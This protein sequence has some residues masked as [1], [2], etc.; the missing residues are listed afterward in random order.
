[1][2]QILFPFFLILPGPWRADSI[3][4]WTCYDLDAGRQEFTVGANSG[5][6][7]Y[8]DADMYFSGDRVWVYTYQPRTIAWVQKPF[9]QVSAADI[10][11][12]EFCEGD[13]EDP[14][15][16]MESSSAVGID[17]PMGWT[18]LIETENRDIY[19]VG[20]IEKGHDN[21]ITFEYQHIGYAPLVLEMQ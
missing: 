4:N 8:T 16:C 5:A 19:K 18:S 20:V 9:G 12:A 2:Y 14:P 11:S 6:C 7:K 17:V 10:D 21:Y 3:H 15:Q 1:M 13:P